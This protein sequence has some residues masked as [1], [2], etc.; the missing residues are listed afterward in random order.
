M[1][2][3]AA[4]HCSA[5]PRST[6]VFLLLLGDTVDLSVARL[7]GLGAPQL[8][9]AFLSYSVHVTAYVLQFFDVVLLFSVSE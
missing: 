8:L 7:R 9:A 5:D 1:H 2:V 6:G 3:L 4:A